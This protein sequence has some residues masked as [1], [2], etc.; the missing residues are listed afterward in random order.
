MAGIDID[1]RSGK[2]SMSADINMVPFIDLLLV[3][4]AFLLI[5]AVWTQAAQLNATTE[6]PSRGGDG[7]PTNTFDV[8][9]RDEQVH[10]AWK[11]GNV[12]IHERTVPRGSTADLAKTFA[13]EWNARGAHRHAA[14]RKVDLAVLHADND[15]PFRDMAEVLDALSATKR[16]MDLGHGRKAVIPVFATTLSAR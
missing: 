11:Q 9:I 3:T 16:E 13:E 10:M 7:E 5:T 15:V 8:R 1:S 4:V 2:R 14:D 12:V 6:V